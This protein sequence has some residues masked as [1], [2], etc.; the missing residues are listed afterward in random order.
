MIGL[1]VRFRQMGDK[2]VRGLSAAEY[3]FFHFLN[4]AFGVD[5]NN[6]IRKYIV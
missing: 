4:N 6:K 5:P 2:C 1:Q 3:H